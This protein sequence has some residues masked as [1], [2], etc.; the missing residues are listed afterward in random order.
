MCLRTGEYTGLRAFRVTNVAHE[1]YHAPPRQDHYV[2][3]LPWIDGQEIQGER[4][5]IIAGRAN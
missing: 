5:E 2:G 3:H 4:S 1:E